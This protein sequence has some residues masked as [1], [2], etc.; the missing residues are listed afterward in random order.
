MFHADAELGFAALA[1]AGAASNMALG[2]IMAPFLKDHSALFEFCL[3][4]KKMG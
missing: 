3:N 4:P 1:F 2:L